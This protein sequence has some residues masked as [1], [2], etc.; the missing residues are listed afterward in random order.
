MYCYGCEARIE[1]ATSQPMCL[2]CRTVYLTDQEVPWYR[3][4]WRELVCR[5]VPNPSFCDP[6]LTSSTG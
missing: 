4:L 3:R 6:R 2:A 1:P 5:F